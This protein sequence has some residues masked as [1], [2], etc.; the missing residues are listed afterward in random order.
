MTNL[1]VKLNPISKLK[2]YRAARK[3]VFHKM[4][5]ELITSE[6]AKEILAYVKEKVVKV[7]SPKQAKNLYEFLSRKFP[8]LQTLENKFHLESLEK[9]DKV[10]SILVENIINKGDFELANKIMEEVE[11]ISDMEKEAQ[12]AE[13]I[14]EKMPKEFEEAVKMI[15]QNSKKNKS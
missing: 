7:R 2:I 9:I 8:E 14:S 3:I 10:L 15:F 13:R 5:K 1:E 11:E 4:T 12:Y 6:R